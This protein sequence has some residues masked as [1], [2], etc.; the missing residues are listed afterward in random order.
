MFDDDDFCLGVLF[1][2]KSFF[3]PIGGVSFLFGKQTRCS[4]TA[5]PTPGLIDGT[6]CLLNFPVFILDFSIKKKEKEKENDKCSQCL[7]LLAG[8]TFGIWYPIRW[9]KLIPFFLE[10]YG[11]YAIIFV[12]LFCL[13]FFF[14][15]LMTG[16]VSCNM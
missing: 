7:E 4:L 3:S 15:L 12:D 6:L 10:F 5:E 9:V 13:F 1:S 8:A 2:S 14:F 11:T 16:W